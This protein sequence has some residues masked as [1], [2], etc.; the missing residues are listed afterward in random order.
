MAYREPGAV[1]RALQRFS[2]MALSGYYEQYVVD[3]HLAGDERVLELGPGAGGLTRHL[4]RRLDKGGRLTSIDI[5]DV[6][7]KALQARYGSSGRL[8]SL[9]G[10]VRKLPLE[11]GSFDI[12]IT[13]WMLHDVE[14]PERASVVA[15]LG[16]LLRPGGRLYAREPTRPQHGMAAEELARLME[17]AGLYEEGRDA[18]RSRLAGPYVAATFVKPAA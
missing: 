15:R 2:A 10:D 14:A 17:A 5:W 13:H 16:D 6:L 7:T 11:E 3:M 9:T 8:E 12:A 4:V 1:E 18:G